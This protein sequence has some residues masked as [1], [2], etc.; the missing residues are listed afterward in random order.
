MKSVD[1]TTFGAFGTLNFDFDD[2]DVNFEDLGNGVVYVDDA[3][4]DNAMELDTS[5]D[6]LSTGVTNIVYT[7]KDNTFLGVAQLDNTNKL[8]SLDAT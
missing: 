1:T 6:S 2:V 4:A 3:F 8:V 5:V 7:D